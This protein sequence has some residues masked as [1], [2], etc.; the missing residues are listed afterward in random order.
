LDQ[1]DRVLMAIIFIFL[2]LG[3]SLFTFKAYKILDF[4]FLIDAFYSM[5]IIY[6]LLNFKMSF[7]NIINE[8]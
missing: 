3:T 8:N 6:N 4:L 7:L 1:L 2:K 5:F